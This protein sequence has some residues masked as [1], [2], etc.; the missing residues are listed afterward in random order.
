MNINI[1]PYYRQGLKQGAINH[2]L[3]D[4]RPASIARQHTRFTLLRDEKAF[5]LGYETGFSLTYQTLYQQGKS[6]L[7]HAIESGVITPIGWELWRD[8]EGKYF[9]EET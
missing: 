2:M 1:A 8:F 6:L 9:I 5:D 4:T 3:G 7:N